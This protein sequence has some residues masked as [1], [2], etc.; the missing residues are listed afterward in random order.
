MQK[1]KNPE[2]YEKMGIDFKA[3]Y[4][5]KYDDEINVVRQQSTLECLRRLGVST[6]LSYEEETGNPSTMFL[7]PIDNETKHVS[8]FGLIKEVGG[9]KDMMGQEL[10]VSPNFLPS[11]NIDVKGINLY[12]R[13]LTIF[14]ATFNLL[15]GYN[16][17]VANMQMCTVIK[18]LNGFEPNLNNDVTK[19]HI[20]GKYKG[21][22]VYC[23]PIMKWGDTT[24]IATSASFETF[25]SLQ[26]RSPYE[27]SSNAFTVH[28]DFS[29]YGGII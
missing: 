25:D 15:K 20:I 21:I 9:I 17:W 19:L 4:V 8:T 27:T 1:L 5:A 22:A 23:N 11:K 2:G 16:V 18:E 6:A 26:F 28:Y 14:D 29:D 7:S 24:L 13:H 3:L 12:Q 10:C